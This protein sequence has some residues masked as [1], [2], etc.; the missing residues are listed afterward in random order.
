MI[1]NI[2]TI[3]FITFI[4]IS[5][6]AQEMLTMPAY[7]PD[8]ARRYQLKSTE[9]VAQEAITLPFYDDF[10]VISVYPSPMR[11]A[12]RYALVNTD[13]AK[14]PPS[15]GV[16]TLDAL[17]DK[18][19]LYTGA[20]PNPFEADNLTSLPIRLDSIFYP[21]KRAITR[22]DSVYLSF[23]YQP[24]GRSIS[25]PSSTASLILEF[26]SPGDS[27]QVTTANGTHNEPRWI[28]KWSTQGGIQVDSFAKP[29]NRYFRQ[30]LIPVIRPSVAG[31]EDSASYLKNGFQFRFRNMA[32]LAGNSQP[33]WRTN[34]SQWNIDVVNLDFKSALQENQDVAF[35]EPAPSMLVNY[36]AMPMRQYAKNFDNEMKESLSISIANLD[37]KNQNRTYN[38]NIRKNSLTSLIASYNGGTYTI[39]PYLTYGYETY[40]PWATPP[41]NVFFP[42][43]NEESVV[44]HITHYLSPDPSPYPVPLNRSNDT[45]RFDQVFSN[46]YAYDNGSSEAG[47]G[48]NGSAGSYAVQFK[49]NITDT[50]RGIQIFF[51]P[52]KDAVNQK[53]VDLNVWNDSNG[54]PGR[55]V[56]TLSGVTPVYT[57]NLNEF[58]TYWFDEPLVVEAGNF[59]GL[60]F[61]IGWS[62]TTLDNLNVGFDRY[63]DSHTKRFY[64]VDGTWQMSDSANYGSLMMRPVVGPAKPL[65]IIK[66]LVAEH[67]SIK[68]N[69]VTDGNLV[70]QLPEAWKKNNV[71]NVDY[72]IISATGSRVQYGSFYNPVNV[73]SLAP[74]FYLVILTNKQSGLK[75]TGKMLIR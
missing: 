71:D 68:P 27:I 44:F 56:K 48:I 42:V 19:K 13:Y 53:L 50:L 46:Y 47:I 14:Y 59:P 38:Y 31:I 70:I 55:I 69:P 40:A 74:G 49:L 43:S 32:T 67:L 29:N 28:E 65:G 23:Y 64:S 73:S 58:Y 20:G 63:K 75:A 16:A 35:A 60:R 25:P 9:S 2:F 21:A 61:Y 24:Q 30:I 1:K 17:D 15:I 72:S 7:N 18:G 62:Q 33:D 5:A 37:N 54:K 11:W 10:S 36:E 6:S 57:S 8:I 3:L 51:N 26:H 22:G 45:I 41:V 4:G 39:K 34:G 12:D 66:S 52:V